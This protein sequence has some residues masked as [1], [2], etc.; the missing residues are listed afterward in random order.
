[1]DAASVIETIVIGALGGVAGGLF[2]VG[3]GII[4]IPL[5]T[6]VFGSDPN[7]FQAASL[8]SAI[9]VSAGAIPRHVRAKA[10]HWRFALHAAA[11]SL[12]TVMLGVWLSNAITNPVVLERIFA[13]F[14]AYVAA[15]EAWKIIQARRA[16]GSVRPDEAD[17][18]SAAAPA[19]EGAPRDSRVEPQAGIIGGVMGIMAGL[20]GIG[21]GTVAVPLMRALTRF[22]LRDAIATSSAMIIVTVVVAATLKVGS[23]YLMEP[24]PGSTPRDRLAYTLMLAALL[25]PGGLLGARIGAQWMHKLPLKPLAAAFAIVCLV[26]AI[27]MARLGA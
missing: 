16:A 14:L 26:L 21:G 18:P 12:V 9:F 27:R 3:G 24:P 13:V 6:I 20:L 23:I 10:I 7:A 17:H 5:L 2:G 11:A 15:F 19:P 4:V 25:A 8:I 22:P 1:M